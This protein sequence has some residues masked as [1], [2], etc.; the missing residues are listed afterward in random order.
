MVN[1]EYGSIVY[2]ATGF[3]G[4]LICDYIYNHQESKLIKWAISGRNQE[5]LDIISE[6]YSLHSFKANSFD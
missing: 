4:K 1:K 6:K 5:K 3:T 2:G